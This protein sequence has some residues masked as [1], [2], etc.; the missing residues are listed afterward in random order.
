[1]SRALA[2]FA[3]QFVEGKFSAETFSNEYIQRW[4]QERDD[5]TLVK[6]PLNQ[7][8]KLSTIFCLADLYNPASDRKD[9]EFD[10]DKLRR[11]V[12][13]VLELLRDR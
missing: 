7:D 12:Q 6:D 11:E 3:K 13:N 9:Y 1:M 2:D 8:G 10:E 5:E 4:R